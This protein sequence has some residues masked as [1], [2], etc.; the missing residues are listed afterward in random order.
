[1]ADRFYDGMS[2]P[3]IRRELNDAYDFMVG[4]VVS[5]TSS[6][7]LT[8]GTGE[9]TLTVEENKAL[10]IGQ[11][12]RIARTSDPL[13][14]MDG[15]VTSYVGT[16]L[17]VLVSDTDGSGTYSDWTVTLSGAAGPQGDEGW[18]P[19]LAVVN[20]GA[21]RVFEVTDWVGG[22]GQKPGT[23]YVG[24]TGLVQDKANAIDVRGEVG[25]TGPAN[26]LSIGTVQ[27]GT[28]GASI[29]GNAPSQTLNLTL[30]KGDTGDDGWSPIL[31]LESDGD[32]R[33]LK[34][35]DW[36]G[37]DG[38]KPGT[39]YIGSSG[40]VQDKASAV[41]V[42][43]SIGLTGPANSLSIGTVQGGASAGATITGA[44][45]TQTLNLTLPTG[46]TGDDGWSPILAIE[47]DN[48]RRVLK[49]TDWTGGDGTKPGTGY[50]GASG[51]VQDKANGVDI[52][53]EPG[54]GAVSS[55]NNVGPDG[56]GDVDIDTDDI[57]EGSSNKYFVPYTA[58]TK[59]ELDTGTETGE[60]VYPPDVLASWLSGKG[61]VTTDTTYT[62]GTK[63]E[64]DTGTENAVRVFAPSVLAAWLSGKGYLTAHQQIK[65]LA[66]QTLTGSGNVTLGDI[67]AA[68][69]ADVL[70]KANNLSDLADAGVARGNL[71]GTTV[72]Q[73]LFTATNPSAIRYPK[74]NADNTVSFRT[75]AQMLTDLGTGPI[76]EKM[77]VNE[78]EEG[79]ATTQRTIDAATLKAAIDEHGGGA[80]QIHSQTFT[81]SGT[82]TKP[83]GISFVFVEMWG[84]GGSGNSRTGY[85][86][87]ASG[88]GG[89]GYACYFI[90]ASTLGAS[91]PVVVGAGGSSVTDNSTGNDGGNSSFGSYVTYGG[92]GATNNMGGDGGGGGTGGNKDFASGETGYSSGGGGAPHRGGN[93]IMGGAGG[94]GAIKNPSNNN[95]LGP[96]PALSAYGGNGGYQSTNT[97]IAAQAPGGGGSGSWKNDSAMASGAGARGEVRVTAW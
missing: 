87:R 21:R 47:A 44:A 66:S 39:G 49:V 94:G 80:T 13:I 43:G 15:V 40:I 72:G 64:L 32:R 73:N 81:S 31:V 84:G 9:K 45:P 37:G 65:T 46:A 11:S 41:D 8:V 54:S 92:K 67:G 27:S 77:P 63:N 71:G 90:V 3:E 28:A 74:I 57:P 36:T 30:P 82:W 76:P 26:S 97:I 95:G 22:Q 33:V 52:R 38:T 96:D 5:P 86:S 78:A 35:D 70:K 85:S 69:D 60:R 2:G 79:V 7:T 17:K 16:T 42:R 88:G 55:V 56:S 93:S 58:G 59:N 25:Q 50:V 48:D 23:G 53:G 18:S 51:L 14:W 12:V 4:A 10:G 34:I 19:V 29:T 62:A 75:A 83:A 89:G 1:M 6:T 24:A 20:D 91:V 61:Y 68:A